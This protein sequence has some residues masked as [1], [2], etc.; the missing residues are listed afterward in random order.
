VVIIEVES[1]LRVVKDRSHGTLANTLRSCLLRRTDLLL[2][3]LSV[4]VLHLLNNS[5]V[6]FDYT[7][8][9]SS[10]LRE[11]VRKVRLRELDVHHVPGFRIVR[12]DLIEVGLG[13]LATILFL[14]DF[15]LLHQSVELEL[16]K[17]VVLGALLR[18]H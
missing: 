12:H 13:R 4:V 9:L 18:M 2:D 11:G 1:A 6:G 15:A 7:R 16:L 5:T 8:C 17:Y 3:V 10:L 14:G